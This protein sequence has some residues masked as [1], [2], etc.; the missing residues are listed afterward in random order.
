[1]KLKYLMASAAMLATHGAVIAEECP[2][3]KCSPF[4]YSAEYKS[5]SPCPNR[6]CL[7]HYDPPGVEFGP[8]DCYYDGWSGYNCE[9]WPRGTDISY[10]YWASSGILSDSGPTYSP[11]V[12]VGCRAWA[13]GEVLSVSVTSPYGLSSSTSISLPC[14]NQQQY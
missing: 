14:Q 11:Y 7:P 13:H 12:W 2:I 6:K 1:M 10:S 5:G 3:P 9:I 4:E 8:S